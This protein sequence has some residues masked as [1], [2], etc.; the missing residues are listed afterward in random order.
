MSGDV[1]EYFDKILE[2]EEKYD[3]YINVDRVQT[4][5]DAKL[6][7]QSYICEM[8]EFSDTGFREI[9][10]DQ[11]EY[12]KACM[13]S[14]FQNFIYGITNPLAIKDDIEVIKEQI[15]VANSFCECEKQLFDNV[16]EN[17]YLEISSLGS[18]CYATYVDLE[19]QMIASQNAIYYNIDSGM[20]KEY[21]SSML[22]S[23]RESFGVFQ[24][25]FNQKMKSIKCAEVVEKT[26]KM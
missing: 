22:S 7:L 16:T 20:E 17:N 26:K 11:I 23:S 5:E 4:F 1:M 21:H 24:Y 8:E 9:R 13:L 10:K 25:F 19:R 2:V 3:N 14:I 6:W 18:F 15:H 12:V